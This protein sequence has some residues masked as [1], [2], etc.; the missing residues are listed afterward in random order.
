MCFL[1]LVLPSLHLTPF[2]GGGLPGWWPNGCRQ[3]T[4]HRQYGL[5]GQYYTNDI[6]ASRH[7]LHSPKI[8]GRKGL[9]SQISQGRNSLALIGSCD[10][11]RANPSERGC[12]TLIGQP[13]AQVHQGGSTTNF[14][15]GGGWSL[16]R[17]RYWGKR[18][19]CGV[20]TSDTPAFVPG[21]R[22]SKI[23]STL[24]NTR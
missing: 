17:R 23:N 19:R 6:T 15:P 10:L 21:S 16:S 7:H 9:L 11:P 18:H 2:S 13:E 5:I 14:A 3:P 4:S 20:D 8:N 22:K 1:S 12:S 24:I